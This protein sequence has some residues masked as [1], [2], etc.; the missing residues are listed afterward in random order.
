[1]DMWTVIMVLG[2]VAMTQIARVLRAKYQAQHGIVEDRKGR[3][4]MLAQPTDS[5]LQREVE[6]LRERVKVLERIATDGRQTHN[7]A[8]E[9]ES[10]RDK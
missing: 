9:I 2:I 1:M 6:T 7:L 10:L 4:Q 5:E 8:A 3:V